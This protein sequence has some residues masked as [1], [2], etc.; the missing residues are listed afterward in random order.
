MSGISVF[1][2]FFINDQ[3]RLKKLKLS[4]FSFENA[5]INN[6]VINVRGEYK[7]EVKRFL[8][9]NINKKKIKVFFIESKNGWIE[10]SLQISKYLKS[11][12]VFY[13]V[14]DHICVG[15]YKYLNRIIKLL[16]KY[17]IDYLPY[18]F[19][20]FGNNIKSF[21]S[22]N[23]NS[24]SELLYKDYNKDSHEKR[25]ENINKKKL[26]SDM[27]I[28]S[29]PSIIHKKIFLKLLNQKDR[30]FY[31]WSKFLP[32]NFEKDQ[33]DTH[34]LP[35]KI[36]ILKKELFASLDDDQGYKNYSL[37]S[38]GRYKFLKIKSKN[39]KKIKKKISYSLFVIFKN[40]LKKN[41]NKIYRKLFF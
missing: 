35:Y 26:I 5:R 37:I 2:N 15:G 24:T 19:F 27:Y 20:L 33:F 39:N 1:A 4:F 7:K 14:E 31:K 3:E 34:W 38:R 10:D 23:L 21:N 8:C 36:G 22:Q 28:I 16:Y 17:K 9:K 18:S 25:I 13:W 30:I 12:Y 11:K 6:W 32:F 29:C 40:Y 41:L